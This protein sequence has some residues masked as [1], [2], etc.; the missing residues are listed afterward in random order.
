MRSLSLDTNHCHT[1]MAV[2]D[3]LRQPPVYFHTR[4][5]VGPGAI[6]TPRFAVERGITHVINC[7]YPEDSPEWFRRQYPHRYACMEAPDSLH[8]NILEWFPM[9]EAVMHSFLRDGMGTV[10]VHCQAGVNRSAYLALTY[11]C[12]NFHMDLDG[13][14][15]TVKRHR[16]CMFQNPIYRN[17][18]REFINGRL[19]RPENSGSVVGSNR[20]RDT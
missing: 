4:I 18:V 12:K 5:L 16:P 13:L 15:A 9:F 1:T 10:Y 14:F 19:S 17:Q 11:V 7:A 3:Y 2:P 20:Y 8:A 6:L